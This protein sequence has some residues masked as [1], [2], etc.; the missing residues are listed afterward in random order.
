MPFTEALGMSSL[1]PVEVHLEDLERLLAA[2]QLRGD[3]VAHALADEAARQRRHDRD[4]AVRRV[5]LVGTDDPVA[6]VLAGILLQPHG[7]AERHTVAAARGL[8][9]L[10]VADLALQLADAALDERLLLAR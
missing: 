3:G 2:R 9:D 1:P 7:G 4:A 6:H 8:D 5:G 10:G